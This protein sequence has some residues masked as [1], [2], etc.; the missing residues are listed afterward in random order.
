MKCR[1]IKFGEMFKAQCLEVK[2]F[3]GRHTRQKLVWNTLKDAN[4][5]VVLCNTEFDAETLLRNYANRYGKD[6][7]VKE[8]VVKEFEV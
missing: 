5:E 8:S 6:S 2:Y 4:G 1:I 3:P 7:V